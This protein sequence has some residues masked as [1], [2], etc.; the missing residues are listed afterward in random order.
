MGGLTSALNIAKNAILAFQT[1]TQVISHNISNLNNEAYCRQ[2]VVETTYPPAPSPVGPIG[3][4]VKIEEIK[5]YFDEFLERNINLKLTD[6]GMFSAEETGLNILESLFN[7][8]GDTGL[9]S[10]LRSFWDSWQVLSDHPENVAARTQIIENGKLITEALKTKFQGLKDLLN[11]IGLKLK[12]IVDTI[13]NLSDQIAKLNFQIVGQ[14]AGGKSANDLR[15]Q[16]DKLVAELSKLTSIQYFE[17][18]NGAYNIILGKGYNLVSQNKSWHLEVSG[19]DVY[20]VGNNG[21]K[22]PLSSKQVSSGELGGWLKLVEQLS[23]EYN[24]EYVSG[25]QIVLNKHGNPISE[26]DNLVDDL[27]L[28]VGDT[29]VFTG[30]DHFGNTI[31]GSFTVESTSTVKDLLTAI[32]SAYN[33]TVKA[34]IKD[35]RLFIEDEFSGPGYLEFSFTQTPHNISFGTFDD[36]AYQRRVESIN[37][38][39]KLKLFGEELVRAVNELH[40]QGV[41]LTFFTKELEGTYTANKYIKELPYYLDLKRNGF[42]YL[43]VKDP[44]GK[45]TPIKVQLNLQADATLNDLVT[46]INQ[47]ISQAGFNSTD[48]KNYEIRAIIRKG[49]L[50][51]QAKDGYSFAF[52]NDTSGILLSTGINLFFVGSDPADIQVNP[53][54]VQH[55]EFLSSGRMDVES[56][57]SEKPF[58]GDFISKNPVS[59]SQTFQVDKVFLRVFNKTGE[60]YTVPPIALYEG[61]L[62]GNGPAANFTIEIKDANGN[63]LKTIPVDITNKTLSWDDVREI[64]NK[65]GSLRMTIQEDITGQKHFKLEL[66][67]NAPP[68][69]AYI[70]ISY[71]TYPGIKYY[72]KWNNQI[73]AYEVVVDDNPSDTNYPDLKT[74]TQMIDK[75]PFIRSYID[76]DNHLVMKLEPDQTDVYGFEIGE[77]FYGTDKNNPSQSFITFLRDQNMLIPSFRS[78]G[79]NINFINS[80][81]SR[82]VKPDYYTGDANL[83]VDTTTT[84]IVKFFDKNG[85]LV[86]SQT[87]SG[88]SYSDLRTLIQQF[89]SINGLKAQIVGDKFYIALD[90]SETGAPQDADYFVIENV[91]DGSWND[92]SLSDGSKAFLELPGISA[93]LFDEKGNPIDASEEVSPSITL[94]PASTLKHIIDSPPPDAFRINLTSGEDMFQLLREINAPE[95]AKYALSARFDGNGNLIIETTG[96]YNTKTFILKD[97]APAIASILGTPQSSTLLSKDLLSL[98]SQNNNFYFLTDLP[99]S[100]KSFTQA[101]FSTQTLTITLYDSSGA[102]LT[103]VNIT[104]SGNTLQDFINALSS[105]DADGD[106][107]PDL[108]ATFVPVGIYDPSNPS[109]N[110]YKILISIND[111]DFTQGT[112]STHISFFTINSTAS[113][114]ISYLRL[115]KF[116]GNKS[117]PQK[118]R[119]NGL[120]N[121]LLGYH[122]NRGDN[123]T[124]QK[125]ADLSSEAREKLNMSTLEDYYSS[126]IGE[127]GVATKSVKDS[128]NFLDDLVRQLK[129]IKD[130]ISGVSLDEEMANLIK[131][132]QAFIAS[133][134][135]ISTVE[136]MFQALI[137]A[138]R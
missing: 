41:G 79:N 49:H 119:L 58:F 106:G 126:M 135:I 74:I 57:R 84:Y 89:D 117:N 61:I 37:L 15:D 25:N 96:L 9:S 98:D 124:A 8:T 63:T 36:P 30:K 69:S 54:L 31:R 14:E 45:I 102:S 35:G 67:Q 107:I 108:S 29:F 60:K 38:A 20:W 129:M 44:S 81:L 2:K 23:D 33:F 77:R 28:L 18:P 62:E 17:T 66:T 137:N 118:T 127:V 83:N 111:K 12:T 115:H 13:N 103:T 132:Q 133:A 5:R 128:K 16:R 24:Y 113:D 70:D 75:L 43:W 50:V 39:G 56:Y 104:P 82:L 101:T 100:G 65:D 92:F 95:N 105:V 110:N 34:Y 86:G 130:S 51:F 94:D 21:E 116:V 97:E 19:T 4:G 6:L 55:P 85:N 125:I 91:S 68:G 80:G 42:F 7:D 87:V 72:L 114:F 109:L 120:I 59:P 122:I 27:G 90:P 47:A 134:K 71:S 53:L 40:V 93:Y 26:S 48:P 112:S 123:R 22:I 64:V 76:A 10:I 136:D 11:Q 121:T 78:D 131:Y 32:E 1:A 46:Q 73:K 52:S 99:V 88:G 3:M 138:K